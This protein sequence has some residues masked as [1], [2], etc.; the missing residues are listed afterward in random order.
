MATPLDSVTRSQLL[1]AQRNEITEYHIYSRL[2]RKVRGSHNAGILQNIG[3][4]E[5]RHYEFWKS[6][7]GTEVKPSRVK[8]AFFTFISR[9]LGLTFG[10]K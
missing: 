3:D 4:D 5:R 6:Y 7:T 8:I 9:V 1:T 2:A 10:L